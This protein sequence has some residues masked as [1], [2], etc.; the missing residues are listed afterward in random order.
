M[1]FRANQAAARLNQDAES[2]FTKSLTDRK[3]G[4]AFFRE[5]QLR[6]GNAVESLPDWHPVLTA[7]TE[8][9]RLHWH[10]S[11]YSSLPIYK[12]CDHTRQFVRGLLTCPYSDKEADL[13]VE[14][15]NRVDGL[16]AERL[17]RPLYMD[18]A[19]PVLIEASDVKLEADGTIR[20]RDAL[21]W[22][23]QATVGHATE[24]EVAETWWNVRSLALGC[25]HGS[26]SSLLVNDF[27][28]R[29]MR[30]ILEALN[31]SGMFGPIKEVSLDMLSERK[32][33]SIGRT[34]LQAALDAAAP[35]DNLSQKPLELKF[36]LRGEACRARIKDTWGDGEEYSLQVSVG[37]SDL[38]VSGFYYPLQDKL[39]HT[40][41]TGKRKLAEKFI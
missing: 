39:E 21:A 19:C 20:G 41:P 12:R 9:P 8:R 30:K 31:D 13:L 40:D 15:V 18:K 29:H 16:Q 1:E 25:P 23:V 17:D 10:A 5:V 3:A 28:G 27:T 26:R 37:K 34:L 24:H 32:R 2:F 11:S 36:E 6:L 14:A 38:S 7:P 22:F 35:L 4:I 33:A